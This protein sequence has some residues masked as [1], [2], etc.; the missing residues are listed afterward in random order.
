MCIEFVY[1]AMLDAHK[2]DGQP[3]CLAKAL[4]LCMA[5]EDMLDRRLTHK[6]G[7]ANQTG[8]FQPCDCF[9]LGNRAGQSLQCA[10]E[11]PVRIHNKVHSVA[12]LLDCCAELSQSASPLLV[13]SN[14]ENDWPLRLLDG[15]QDLRSNG[16]HIQVLAH[17]RGSD[18]LHTPC[19]HPI[20]GFPRTKV[21]GHD[22]Q[23]NQNH[24]VR[25]GDWQVRQLSGI[26]P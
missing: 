14:V 25:W 10:G 3:Q 23:I 11:W 21:G 9:D 22:V 17:H 19:L 16:R 6:I 26:G 8:Y 2:S 5:L 1:P 12:A 20:G 4:D 7:I 13:A 18:N 24:H 15:P